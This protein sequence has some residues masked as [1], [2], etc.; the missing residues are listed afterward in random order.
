[1]TSLTIFHTSKKETE[2]SSLIILMAAKRQKIRLAMTGNPD[3]GRSIKKLS[4]RKR[5]KD[6][7]KDC[8]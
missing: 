3:P 6:K 1:M 4:R 8:F 5:E 7:K 2:K